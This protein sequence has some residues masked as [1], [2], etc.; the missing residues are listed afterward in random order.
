M[1]KA[2]E[3]AKRFSDEL[4]CSAGWVDGLKLRH[5]SFGKEGGEERGVNSDTTTE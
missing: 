2:E 5:N 3:F 4:I 1:T